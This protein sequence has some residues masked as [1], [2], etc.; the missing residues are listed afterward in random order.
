MKKTGVS[1][2]FI[3]CA[4]VPSLDSFSQ[5]SP[6]PPWKTNVEETRK[7]ALDG[8]KPCVVILNVNA[9]AL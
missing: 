8:Q 1:V 4:L 2:L 9:R 3:T 5:E 6:N 7:E